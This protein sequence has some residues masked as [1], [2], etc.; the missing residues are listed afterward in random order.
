MSTSRQFIV[1]G[2][3]IAVRGAICDV[4]ERTKDELLGLLNQRDAWTTAIVINAQYPQANLPELPRLSLDLSQ[5]GFGLKI[6]LNLTVDREISRP[7]VRREILR[8]LLLELIYRGEPDM[9]AGHLYATPPDWLLDG[10]PEEQSDLHG[11]RA[12]ELL[13]LPLA[14]GMVMPLEQ[15]LRQNP[16]LLDATGRR[17]YRAYSIAFVGFLTAAREGRARLGRFVLDLR[18]ASNDPVA[19]LRKHFP[20]IFRDVSMAE[21]MWKNHLARIAREQPYQ[22]LSGAETER[23]LKRAL[24]LDLGDQDGQESYD[25]AEFTKF[26]RHPSAKASLLLLA[27]DLDELGRRANPIYQPLIS[28]YA[29]VAALL[30]RGKT[31]GLSK[32]IAGLRARHRESASRRRGIDDYLNWFEAT[33]LRRPSG[34]FAEYMKV[35]EAAARPP[36]SK[37]DP[38]S[39]YL[40]ALGTE[41][42]D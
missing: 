41:F 2:T 22:S 17:L 4:A 25:L 37:R 8:A 3:Q 32:R 12:S 14:S 5:T 6:Q 34:A 29:K 28:E 38:I 1:Y 24:S 13:A 35:A 27:R 30:A 31:R 19:D 7:E 10:V 36:Q 26:R 9:P 23:R 16:Q 33:H 20:E 11:Q 42:E 18:S 40:D 21:K 39:I 15:L